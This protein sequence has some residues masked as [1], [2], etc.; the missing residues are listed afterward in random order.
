M[1]IQANPPAGS[2]VERTDLITVTIDDIEVKVPKNTLL[3]R[4]AE[5]IGIQIPRFC[6]HPLLD[7]VGAC[8][9]CLVEIT[10]AGNGRG[11]PKPQASCTITVADGMVVRTQVTS[12]V[13]DKAQH[14]NME[15]LLIN[16]PL[17]C[18]V[19]DK[20]GECPLQNQAMTNGRGESR[21]TEIKRTYPKPINISAEV[22]LDR[23]RCVLCARCTRFSEQIAGDPFIALVERGALQQV[24]IY[25]KE[26]FESYFSGNTIQIC[27]VGALTSAAYR[28]R[29]RPFD[30]VSVPSVAEHD[31][32]GAAI[33][34]DYRRGKVMRRLAGDDPQ[35]NEEWIS[36]KD[37]FAFNYASTGDR[38]THPLIREDGELR[39]ASWPEALTFAAERLT[40]ARGNAAVLTGGRLTLEDSY[41]YSKFARVVLGTNDIDFRARPHSAEEADFLAAA[42]AGTGLGTTFGD[43]EKAGSVL[44]VGFEPEEEAPSVFLR[45]RKGVRAHGT[46]VFTVAAYGSR[47]IEKL[48]GVVVPA[49]PGTEAAVLAD[50]GN[51][52]EAGAAALAS[53]GA[54]SIIIVG[55]RLAGVPGGY[56]TALRVA[57][58]TGAQL[59]WI[60]RRAGD[61]G[62]LE[63]GCLPGLLPGGRL[64]SDPQARV[65]MQAAWGVDGLPAQPG[66]DLTEILASAGSLQALVVAG[67]EID[68]LPDPAAA[69][70]ALEAAPFVV[71]FEVRNSQVTEHAD[72]VFPVVPPAEKDGT[73][74]NW[75]GRERSFP[76]VLKVPA[77]MPDVRALAALAQEMD[78]SIG[79]ATPA[80]AKREFDE[81]G[82]WD[83]DRAQEPTYQAGPS[84]GAFD[85]TR[86]ATWRMLIDD[87][88]AN[89][90]E[91][92]LTATARTPVARI[93]LTTAH[94]VGVADGDELVVS[95]DA[96]SIRLPV[97][98]TPMSD[99]V[100]WLPANSA[101]SHVRRSL[102]AD[103]GSI[104][105]IAGGNS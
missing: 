33:R 71:S 28:F 20:G 36:D 92:H 39:P 37:R 3:I 54:D 17:D 7:P 105:T 42:V 62:A 46:K 99:N 47:G 14:G 74:V 26:P 21:F 9:Q 87:S 85:S 98:I 50:L 58:D 64:V 78:R 68:D 59:A 2:E 18:P 96:G 65:D 22:L 75:E 100:V 60:P 76:V 79:F 86:L 34:V 90:G 77:A 94:R 67:V 81:L 1:T 80:G 41:A 5:Q 82:R 53:L 102:H 49:S 40:A 84:L 51:A 45:L 72:V 91:P 24:G 52:G 6:D 70:A 97:V 35:V 89:D 55:E 43:L 12:P 16:H 15:F 10:D 93:S 19:C 44:L 27:P 73:F 83:G 8:R 69:L 104:V 23:E 48:D 11:M 57:L 38:L 32:S 4:A 66:R 101:D 30:L 103:H 29:S 63:A 25:E 61:R 31:S 95:T 56:S 13:A 88:R